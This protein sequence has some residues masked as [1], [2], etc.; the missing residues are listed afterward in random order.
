M[1]P[2]LFKSLIVASIIGKPVVPFAHFSNSSLLN[3]LFHIISLFFNGPY[4]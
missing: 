4:G 1:Y 2:E 3:S